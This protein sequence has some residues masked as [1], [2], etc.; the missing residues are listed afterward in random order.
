MQPHGDF[1][2]LVFFADP[3]LP[4]VESPLGPIVWVLAVVATQSSIDELKREEAA[5]LEPAEVT[6]IRA[7]NPLLVSRVRAV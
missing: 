5:S 7:A 2:H 6:R 4:V 3:R 1:E